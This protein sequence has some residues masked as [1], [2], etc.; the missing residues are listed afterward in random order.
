MN[1]EQMMLKNRRLSVP[2]YQVDAFAGKAFTGNPAAVCWL[3][4]ELDEQVMQSIAAE[5]NLSET[6]FVYPVINGF[7]LRWFTPTIEVDLCGHA[8]LAAAHILWEQGLLVMEE[9]A[10]FHT[11]S[12]LLLARSNQEG[13]ELDFPSVPAIK[14]A[15][16]DG[17]LQALGVN[18]KGDKSAEV[19]FN[20]SD[21]LVRFDDEDEVYAL[22]PDFPKLAKINARGVIVTALSRQTDFDFISRFFGPA[23]GIN[24]DPVTGSAHCTLAPYWAERIGKNKMHA[25][26]ASKR[27]GEVTVELK[28]ERV[29]LTGQAITVVEGRLNV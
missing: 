22:L 11:R 7:N 28:N 3:E 18:D 10:S 25:F 13:I 4:N 12:G 8:T 27:G 17:L 16:P 2:I 5:M 6:A 26:Q 23:A 15:V 19:L 14:C 29:L 21:Y 24:E 20:Q 1:S 9:N